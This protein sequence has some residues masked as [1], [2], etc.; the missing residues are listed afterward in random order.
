[1]DDAAQ[2]ISEEDRQL[3]RRVSDLLE[4]VM[5]TLEITQ[6][7]E[8]MREIEEARQD[9]REGRVRDYSELR[10]ELR[11]TGKIRVKDD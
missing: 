9:A 2:L 6:N 8:T 1:M 3:L 11:K 7:Q 10:E 5:E 4:E